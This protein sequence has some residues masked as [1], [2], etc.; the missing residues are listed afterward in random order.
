MRIALLAPFGIRTKGTARARTLPLARALVRHG[1]TVAVFIPP[2]DSIED[3]GQRWNDAGVEVINV[4]LPPGGQSA[5]WHWQLGWRLYQ[6]AVQWRPHVV[7]A[8]K[9]KGPSGLAATLLWTRRRDV[10]PRLIVDSDDWEGPGGWNDNP[11]AGY[12]EG[13]K[14]FFTWQE[15][16]G[17]SHADAWT[18]TSQCL[19]ERAIGF[20]AGPENV[21]ILPNGVEASTYGD[22]DDVAPLRDL[23]LPS[24]GETTSPIPACVV[25]YTRFAGTRP[26]DVAAIWRRIRALEPD[27]R[28]TII[29]RGALGEE[30]NL[31]L[32]PGVEVKGW[33]AADQIHATL[34]QAAVAIAPWRDTPANCARHSAKILELM[35]A[36]LPVVA[37]R[38]GEIP[39]TLGKTGVLVAPGDPE[40]FARAVVGLIHDRPRRA[41]LGTA[42]CHRVCEHFNWDVLAG[43]ALTAYG[44]P[45]RQQ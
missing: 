27:A 18:V 31:A 34:V 26:D 17:L 4:S 3:A 22:D 23:G 8:F 32:L 38:V 12:S 7:H 44:N 36:G 30:R 10:R 41:A 20:G 15:R 11:A 9:P 33:L 39:S 24:R 19:A 1:H 28:L 42:A 16:F 29:G 2:Y 14:R 40:D 35:A 13:Q 43:V 21:R 25:L 45:Q 5:P 37:T 6:A